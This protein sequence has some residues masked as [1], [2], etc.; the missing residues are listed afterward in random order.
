[1]SGTA[2]ATALLLIELHHR[3]Q[4]GGD[5]SA[6]DV[7]KR[8]QTTTI[9]PPLPEDA[10]CAFAYLFG[11]MRRVITVING[12]E[13]LSADAFAAEEAGLDSELA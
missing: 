11:A 6:T 12:L 9:L 10:F 13:V 2:A 7:R 8:A 3:Y 5:E 4:P 1:M